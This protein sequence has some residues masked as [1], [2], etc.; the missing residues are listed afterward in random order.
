MRQLPTLAPPLL[1]ALVLGSLLVADSLSGT[2]P[3][4]LPIRRL[5]FLGEARLPRDTTVDGALLGGLSGLTYD[6]QRDVFHAIS[7]DPSQRAPARFYTVS[8]DLA[9]GRL[10]QGDVTA[11][12]VTT[13]KTSAGETF[14]EK[15]LDPEGIAL[16][17]RRTLLVSSE[18]QVDQ[19]VPPW[20]REFALDGSAGSSFDLDRKFTPARRSWLPGRKHPRGVRHNLA[21]ESLTLSPGGSLFTATENALHQDGPKA[22]LD[23]GSPVRIVRYDTD[24][25]EVTAE[26]LYR[27]EPVP[28]APVPADAF[29]VNGLVEL[30][31]FD[32]NRLLTLERA[33]SSGVGNHVRLFFVDLRTA[34]N[35]L[36]VERLEQS[37][38]TAV[39]KTFLLDFAELGIELDNLE[40]M[41]FGP[42]LADGRRT[43]ILVSDDNF[44]P[45][46]QVTQFLAF[47]WSPNPVT[48]AAIQ[49]AGH[50]SPLERSWVFDIP[51]IVTATD[52]GQR[53]PGF[54][55]QQPS[56]SD[57]P[58]ASSGLF[59]ST[60]EPPQLEPGDR[61]LATGRVHEAGRRG[62]LTVTQ[63]AGGRY[64]PLSRGNAL[65]EPIR[66]GADGHG[67]RP[68]PAAWIDDD[69]LTL[70][71]PQHDAIDFFESLE[72]MYVELHDPLVVGPGD[73]FGGCVVMAGGG[74]R[75]GRTTP[76]GVLVSRENFNPGRLTVSARLLPESDGTASGCRAAVGERFA[77]PVRGVLHYDFGTFRLLPTKLLPRARR[78]SLVVPPSPPL[79][80]DRGH[81]TIATYNLWN[82]EPA[83]REN[84]RLE[85]LARSIVDDLGAP[86]ILAV[87]EVQDASGA[88]DDGVVAGNATF[89]ALTQ[90]ISAAGGPTYTFHQIDPADGEDG[91]RPGG[92]IRVGFLVNPTRV[93]VLDRERS[94][95]GPPA[96]QTDPQGPLLSPNPGRLGSSDP[97][98]AESVEFGYEPSRKPLTLETEFCGRRLFLVNLHLRSKR[99]DDRLFGDR[100]PPLLH[101]EEQRSEQAE[102]VRLLVEK[103]LALDPEA[104]VVVL[105]DLNEY[106]FRA[107][108][109]VL[110]GDVLEN[111]IERLPPD[112]RYTYIYQ[113]NSMVL[114]HVLVSHALSSNAEIQAIHVNA[115]LPYG[116]RA[117]DHDPVLA[118]L[119]IECLDP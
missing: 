91:G 90:A 109:R 94:T 71:E 44:A 78:S 82:L 81:L 97:A 62:A 89:E 1:V 16:S 49:G 113:G 41:S 13:L 10:E 86:D 61:V 106:T 63:L 104:A 58:G 4:E 14:A 36:S 68:V 15:T 28:H 7:D 103:I 114:D 80:G 50:R 30:L 29:R 87:Q 22:D 66:L 76:G 5:A 45:D 59:V 105:G 96:V 74:P 27:T 79:P 85:R 54:W 110:A 2:E 35:V 84:S 108:L 107:P 31:A 116:E 101:S 18:G 119:A 75:H 65:P 53:A 6:R 57:R 72:G 40:G 93:R 117:S 99:A 38:A 3:V 112:E 48:I 11:V 100:Q 51:G 34:T 37:G 118:R 19:G 115:D 8:I 26:Y 17:P 92:N 47:A 95:S 20:L 52:I 33:Y 60:H 21:L 25:G 56:G 39:E 111:L 102:S 88:K 9:D 83:D 77:G 67:G 69:G 70:F 98:F 55:I 32:E 24:T 12:A 73:R 64:Q 42:T 43:L 46:R 23:K